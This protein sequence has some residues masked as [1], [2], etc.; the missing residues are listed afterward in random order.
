MTEKAKDAMVK[1]LRYVPERDEE[2]H[3]E[4]YQ[5]SALSQWNPGPGT[6]APG[7]IDNIG[8]GADFQSGLAFLKIHYSDGSRGILILSCHAPQGGVDAIP[9]GV[10]LCKD[11]VFFNMELPKPNV[12]GDRTS[13]HL[14]PLVPAR[15]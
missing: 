13:F 12:D 1:V 6:E 10:S 9:E 15:G 3:W 7:T 14:V 11:N 8:R 5:V 4:T 2:P